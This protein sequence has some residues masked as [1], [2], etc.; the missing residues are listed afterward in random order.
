VEII[1][2]ITCGGVPCAL[3]DIWVGNTGANMT[4]MLTASFISSLDITEQ[5]AYVV[6]QTPDGMVV[7]SSPVYG[8]TQTSLAVWGNDSA[9]DVLDGATFGEEISLSLVDGNKLYNITLP[10]SAQI[11]YTTNNMSIQISATSELVCPL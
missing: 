10:P 5:N 2:E 4:V 11:S 9:T 1:D 8:I 7:G 3:P 6:A